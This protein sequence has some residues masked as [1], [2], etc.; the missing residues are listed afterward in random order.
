MTYATCTHAD[1]CKAGQDPTADCTCFCQMVTG[2]PVTL[3]TPTK[4][5]CPAH[6]VIESPLT[7][8]GVRDDLDGTY[9]TVCY[10]L[11]LERCGVHRVKAVE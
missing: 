5:K 3:A 9:C 11:M 6:G 10:A 7:V 8:A 4:Y 2:A 1:N